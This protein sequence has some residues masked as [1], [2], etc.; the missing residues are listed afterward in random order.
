MALTKPSLN[1]LSAPAVTLAFKSK[2]GCH[3]MPGQCMEEYKAGRKKGNQMNSELRWQGSHLFLVCMCVCV[4]VCVWILWTETSCREEIKKCVCIVGWFW[5][6]LHLYV[7]FRTICRG[8]LVVSHLS[9]TPPAPHPLLRPAVSIAPLLVWRL[10]AHV[11]ASVH[12]L[13]FESRSIS[14]CNSNLRS[15]QWLVRLSVSQQ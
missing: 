4:C 2:G 7:H 11:S 6:L 8:I 15:P 9:P 3:R 1:P 10:S 13:V 14:A 12:S 5:R